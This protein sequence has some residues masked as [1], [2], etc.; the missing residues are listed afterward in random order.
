MSWPKFF[1][2]G[3]PNS[4]PGL[5]FSNMSRL[6]FIMAMAIFLACWGTNCNELRSRWH[7]FMSTLLVVAKFKQ[8][9]SCM[10]DDSIHNCTPPQTSSPRPFHA[11]LVCKIDYGTSSR[12]MSQIILGWAYRWRP[13]IFCMS[14]KIHL[15][16]VVMH[17][18]MYSTRLTMIFLH[19][20]IQSMPCRNPCRLYIHL[21]STYSISPS[22]VVW[23][24]LDRLHLFHQWKC[25]KCNG[26]M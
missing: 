22:S 16:E 3:L 5:V 15:F 13:R 6:P 8:N 23:S 2:V 19:H 9:C 1:Y 25:F 10:T 14:F 26:H 17:Y 4:V 12:G 11:L 24:K 18:A 20:R 21:A 7:G